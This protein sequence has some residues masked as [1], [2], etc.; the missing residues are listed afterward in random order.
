MDT[1]NA[2]AG[3][4]GTDVMYIDDHGLITLSDR[5]DPSSGANNPAVPIG[6]GADSKG[7]TPFIFGYTLDAWQGP[8]SKLGIS[9]SYMIATP[10]K[11]YPNYGYSISGIAGKLIMLNFR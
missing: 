4:L 1:N 10:T 3:Y 5:S 2:T 8:S 7:C 6:S 11:S 9:Q